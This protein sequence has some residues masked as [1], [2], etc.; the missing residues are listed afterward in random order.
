MGALKAIFVALLAAGSPAVAQPA[1]LAGLGEVI[2]TANRQG[3]QYSQQDRPVVG[4]R[5]TADAVLLQ[6]WISSDTRDAEI[7]KREIHAVLLSAITR[8]AAAGMEIVEG[9]GQVYPVT[10]ANYTD[11]AIGSGGRIDTGRVEV[12]VKTKLTGSLAAA[13]TRLRDFVKGLPKSGRGVAEGVGTTWLTVVDPDQYRDAII[14]LVA[15]DAKRVS[16]AFGPDFTFNVVGIDGQVGW[17]QA[18]RTE[19]FLHLP[20]RYSVVPRQG[21]MP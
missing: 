1:S 12:R 6:F 13:E 21:R 11:V 4:L 14:A 2:V 16:A 5:R 19:V 17:S 15:Q 8:A 3:L 7:R 10:K 9:N 20:Y 18:S